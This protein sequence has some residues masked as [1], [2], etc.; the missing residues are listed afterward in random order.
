MMNSLSQPT[1]SLNSNSVRSAQAALQFR[2]LASEKTLLR[3]ASPRLAKRA[4]S[5]SLATLEQSVF[6]KINQF[7]QQKG[8]AP[9]SLNIT[10]TQQA[11]QH[12]QT[13]ASSRV[14][15]HDGFAGRVKAISRSIPYTGAAENVAYNKGF[16][17]PV[18]QAV[19]G[20]LKSPGHLKNIMGNYKLTG[21]G[22]AQNSQGEYYFTQIFL[23]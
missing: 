7:R 13:M 9:L 19:N 17:D 18:S 3:Q 21:V 16:S 20:W 10:I 15:S 6:Q 23:R 12:S 14:L 22:V 11:R 8:L 1:R 5:P 4:A 2:G